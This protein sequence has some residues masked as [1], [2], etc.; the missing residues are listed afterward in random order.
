M[1]TGAGTNKWRAP[2]V[3]TSGSRYGTPADIYSFGILLETLYPN[4]TDAS[5]EWVT[6]LAA[7][8]TAVNPT[9]RPTAAKIVDLLRPNLQAQPH[10]VTSM[11]TFEVD[12]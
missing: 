11:P 6:T 4:P 3:L 1:T 10:L 8:C 12:C 5:T 2:E 9:R 7:D